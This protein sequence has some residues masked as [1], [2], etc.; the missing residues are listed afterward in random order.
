MGAGGVRFPG[1]MG[2]TSGGGAASPGVVGRYCTV[3]LVGGAVG[4]IGSDALSVPRRPII[5]CSKPPLPIGALLDCGAGCTAGCGAGCT[6][7]CGAGCTA[8][9]GA[10][11]VFSAGA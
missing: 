2:S 4:I 1:G 3:V 8:G 5:D 11:G 6:A 7:G 9:C 10:G